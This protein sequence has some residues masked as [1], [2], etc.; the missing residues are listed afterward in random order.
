MKCLIV[1]SYEGM[2]ELIYR[3]SS[4]V[5][6]EIEILQ[7][8]KFSKS[9]LKKK[10]L[11]SEAEVVLARGG[12]FLEIKDLLNKIV[13]NIEVSVYDV[14]KDV[15]TQ[16]IKDTLLIGFSNITNYALKLGELT[17][18]PFNILTIDKS[19]DLDKYLAYIRRFKFVH[20][21]LNS[22]RYLKKRGIEAKMINSH[23]FS[24]KEAYL[25]GKE[26]YT[27]LQKA[28]LNEKIIDSYL[29]DERLNTY[30]YYKGN[31]IMKRVVFPCY[32]DD[33]DK[34]INDN[35]K[36]LLHKKDTEITFSK[37]NVLI[38]I[39]NMFFKVEKES[40]VAVKVRYFNFKRISNN[41]FQTFDNSSVFLSSQDKKAL[42]EISYSSFPSVIISS[43]SALI[44]KACEEIKNDLQFS[45]E[46][47]FVNG[48]Y[49][50]IE[51]NRKFFLSTSSPLFSSSRLICFLNCE[52]IEQWVLQMIM[53]NIERGG[54]YLINKIVFSF[55]REFDLSSFSL[56]LEKIVLSDFNE[57][58]DKKEL[59]GN[60]MEKYSLNFS[61]E[62]REKIYQMHFTYGQSELEK[63]LAMLSSFKKNSYKDFN[64]LYLQFEIKTEGERKEVV[65]LEKL[66]KKA[67]IEALKECGGNKSEAAKRLKIGRA[68]LYR[69]LER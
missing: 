39:H 37:D 18:Y 7:G 27:S 45:S 25:K 21:D 44:R 11:E 52:K 14:L 59:I 66:T 35:L 43:D 49:L 31:Q 48:E 13:I 16:D 63:I 64:E 3:L 56:P 55:S 54:L 2:D 4:E 10:V 36:A 12:N 26:V 61:K 22:M 53:N 15:Q 46:P 41:I 1:S 69:I 57:L 5:E 62:D 58:R 34:V 65:S 30:V 42:E 23:Y 8:Y 32:L 68:T 38:D 33:V 47:L 9:K 28:K 51:K 67:V 60:M 50:N 20:S 29:A 24:I 19:E 17:D 6:D 40:Y